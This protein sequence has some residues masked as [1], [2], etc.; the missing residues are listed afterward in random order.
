[1]SVN[2]E[3]LRTWVRD[4][5]SRPAGSGGGTEARAARQA[6]KTHLLKEI[7]E[8]RAEHR[9]A[10]GA[11]R[12]HAELRG[13][14]HTVNRRRVATLMR[15]HGTVGYHPRRK[16]HTSNPDRLAPPTPDLVQRGFT[17]A[18]LDERWCGD[19]TYIQVGATW[20]YLAC[21]IGICSHR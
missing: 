21:V 7:R 15:K 19:I 14:G 3:T 10:Y 8:I 6:R 4:A 9:D 20:L 5:D 13:V 11:L 16:K 18:D 1:M 17:A 12:V 2:M